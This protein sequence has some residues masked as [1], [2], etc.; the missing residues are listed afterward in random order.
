MMPVIAVAFAMSR[1]TI[2]L[3][4]VFDTTSPVARSIRKSMS[5]IRAPFDFALVTSFVPNVQTYAW[6]ECPETI[7]S[8]SGDSWLAMSMI[9]PVMSDDRPY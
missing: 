8:M 5:V 2:T 4:A 3:R 1:L 6:C 9:E 7:T